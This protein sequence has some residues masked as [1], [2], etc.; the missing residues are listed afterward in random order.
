MGWKEACW[1]SLLIYVLD[2]AINRDGLRMSRLQSSLENTS[3]NLTE[4]E[5]AAEI[6][7]QIC[8]AV[9]YLHKQG[10]CHRDLKPDNVLLT[11]GESPIIKVSD[12]GLAKIVDNQVSALQ[13]GEKDWLISADRLFSKRLAGHR[14]IWVSSHNIYSNCI[15]TE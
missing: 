12:F 4:E 5:P 9:E 10:I 3:N 6:A 13:H 2:Y 14:H 7:R 11:R 15:L 1:S 8:L